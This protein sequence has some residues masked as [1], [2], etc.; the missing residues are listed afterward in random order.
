ML[1]VVNE[2]VD[3]EVAQYCQLLAA[4]QERLGPLELRIALLAA[5][6]DLL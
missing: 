3:I 6:L 5:V 2:Q 4:L 1:R